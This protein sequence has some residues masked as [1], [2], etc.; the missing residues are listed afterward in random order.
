MGRLSCNH[1][2]TLMV[3]SNGMLDDWEENLAVITANR[4]KDDELVII[5]LGDCLWRERSE[6]TAAHICYLVA[7][8]NFE[9][10]SDSARLCLVGADH[11][12]FPRTYASPEAIQRTEL[13]EYSRVLG[14]SQ[15]ILLPFQPYKLIYG[16]MLAEVGK[17]SDSLKYCHA[18]LK[19]LKFSRA[20]EVE[21]WKQ[22]VLSLEERLRTHQQGGYAASLAPSK[23]VDKLLNF[24]DST[25]HKVVG[26]P[27]PIAP[28]SSHGSV[29]GSEHHQHI[30][31]RVFNSQSTMAMSSLVPSSS[32]EPISEWTAD[33]N[34]M[35]KP[36]RSV[37]EPDFGRRPGQEAA[38]P[39]TG[40]AS[41]SGGTSRFSRFSFGSQLL[42][43][44]VGLLR[45]HSGRQAKLGEENKFYYDEKLKRWVEEGAEPPAEEAALP[46]PPTSA[47][48]QSAKPEYDL[49]SALKT[50]GSPS[51][52]GP[53]LRTS[54]PGHAPGIPPM[55]PTS[56]HFSGRGR[57]GVRSRYVDT[58][59]QGGGT[60]A[61]LFQSP[62]LSVKRALPTNAKFFIPAPA[63]E[64][65]SY[66]QT[67]ES[68]VES[69]QEDSTANADPLQPPN[70]TS[71]MGMQR[72][73][74]MG[75]IPN[76]GATPNGVDSRRT[77]SW[78]GGNFAD[79]LRPPKIGEIKP[80]GEALGRIPSSFVPDEPSMR[81]NGS[82]G[83]DLHEV[84]L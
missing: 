5:H 80:L 43:K 57:M 35:T 10:Y 22:L 27:P 40:K 3:G 29:H 63:P 82:F 65:S 28:S 67:M 2:I 32:I 23:L 41:V 44:T 53:D 9:S 24:F 77:T 71:S 59:N 4:T 25:A 50:E 47:A 7:E 61:K 51:N 8:A 54:T 15:F 45:P 12:K 78:G 42:Q 52:E 6:I 31:P 58:F 21:N 49:K 13:Y 20:P 74:S 33:G 39:D 30:A 37:S 11:W 69:N 84:Q 66:E 17:V 1:D 72:F 14:N 64:P 18:V 62:A 60:S 16:Y 56:N 34:R 81:H 36:N 70:T 79:S 83:E 73:P 38:S 46:P 55:P 26:G 48:F 19:S 76:N 68:T 75:N